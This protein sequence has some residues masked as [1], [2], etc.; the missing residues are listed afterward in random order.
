[1]FIRNIFT[2]FY[3]Y[4]HRLQVS[5]KISVKWVSMINYY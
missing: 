2:P 1:M 5:D 3:E 4:N